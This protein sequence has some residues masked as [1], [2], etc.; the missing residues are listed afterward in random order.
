MTTE[1]DASLILLTRLVSQKDTREGQECIYT[2]SVMTF[3][4]NKRDYEAIL[5]WYKKINPKLL[6]PNPD[7][8]NSYSYKDKYYS[9]TTR[10]LLNEKHYKKCIDLSKEALEEIDYIM[11][12]DEAWFKVRIAKASMN[13]SNFD[14]AIKYFKETIKAKENWSNKYAFAD[15]YYVLG[16]YDNAL[17]QALDAA[18]TDPKIRPLLKINLYQLLS[19]LLNEKG[20]ENEID[21]LDNLIN[22]IKFDNKEIADEDDEEYLECISELE[23]GVDVK[24]MEENL[25]PIW[26]KIL[27]EL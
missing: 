8:K 9:N 27:S 6:N 21:Y 3:I 23:E 7:K 24:S 12:E 16:D 22:A 15:C 2:D 20:Y 10:A 25:R 13:I 5:K 26:R 18:L 14:E 4:S 1:L 19:E 11:N 17:K